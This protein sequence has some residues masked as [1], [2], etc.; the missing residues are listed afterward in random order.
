ML[1]MRCGVI[2]GGY[3]VVFDAKRPNFSLLIGDR[4]PFHASGSVDV[5]DIDSLHIML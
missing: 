3:T 1:G 5:P 4:V 2:V